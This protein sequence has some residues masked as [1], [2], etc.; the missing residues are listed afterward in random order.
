MATFPVA[1]VAAGVALAAAALVGACVH[2]TLPDGPT[3]EAS[4]PGI[5]PQ[6]AVE[7]FLRAANCVASSACTTKAQDIETMGNLF[8]TRD[9]SV[10]K[11][12]ARAE[13]E[14]RMF[15]LAS[16]L[17]SDDYK[18]QGQNI[19]PGRLGA[20]VDLLVLLKQNGRE[21][22]LPITMVKAKGGNWL[23]EKIDVKPL[24]QSQ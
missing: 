10:I 24:Q 1:R 19:V 5:A 2:K 11:R 14:Q 15:A 18:V 6:L 16:L 13:V 20:A 7:R 17:Q 8:G 3:M 23:V 12:D 22:Q 9:G 21:V 4:A